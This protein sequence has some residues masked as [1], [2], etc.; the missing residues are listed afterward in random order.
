MPIA[1]GNQ[2]VDEMF[3][4]FDNMGFPN[5]VTLNKDKIQL[6]S[7]Y[8]GS[9]AITNF[10]CNKVLSELLSFKIDELR[11]KIYLKEIK[12]SLY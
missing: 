3:I 10:S 4:D 6:Y 11:C 2:Q 12:T 9:I 8:S 5:I 1:H 7:K